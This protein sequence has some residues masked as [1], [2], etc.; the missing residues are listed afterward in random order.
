MCVVEIIKIQSL[1]QFEDY[2]TVLLSVFPLLCVRSL[3]LTYLLVCTLKQHLCYP[4]FN[5]SFYSELSSASFRLSFQDWLLRDV[6]PDK[7]ILT[8]LLDHFCSWKNLFCTR[9]PTFS[10]PLES[11]TKI[12]FPFLTIGTDFT[13]SYI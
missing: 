6:T 13:H 7:V 9:T 8:P 12:S 10:L 11:H 5:C 2:N 3:G 4:Y 1:S